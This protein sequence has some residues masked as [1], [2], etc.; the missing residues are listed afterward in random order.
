MLLLIAWGV[1]LLLLLRDVVVSGTRFAMAQSLVLSL[2]WVVFILFL[3]QRQSWARIAI[4]L[5]IA[6]VVLNLSFSILRF[7]GAIFG[8]RW[9][10]IIAEQLL[11]ICAAFLL[12]RPESNGWFKK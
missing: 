1:P 9:I 4:V 7:G 12:F 10:I 8:W 6:L 2:L 11:R 5:M 3:W